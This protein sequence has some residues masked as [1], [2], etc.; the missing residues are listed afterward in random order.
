VELPDR[1]AYLQDI[2]LGEAKRRGHGE[3]DLAHLGIA[4]L[5]IEEATV[6]EVLGRDAAE[7]LERHL[8][9]NREEFV[10][11]R[12]AT[13]AEEALRAT[14]AADGTIPSRGTTGSP[15]NERAPRRAPRRLRRPTPNEKTST[16]CSPNWTGSSGWSP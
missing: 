10:I 8:G 6:L 13:A 16:A 12:L 15:P 4:A 5:R 9:K 1:L 7:T 2:A 14:A 11:P 3:V